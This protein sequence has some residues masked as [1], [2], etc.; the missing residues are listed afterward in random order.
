MYNRHMYWWLVQHWPG[1][2]KFL[3]LVVLVV[4]GG[5]LG[6]TAI[7][8]AQR[9]GGPLSFVFLVIFIAVVLLLTVRRRSTS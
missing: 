2:L 1:P 8:I 7:L 6:W 3:G 9:G 5:T 4:I